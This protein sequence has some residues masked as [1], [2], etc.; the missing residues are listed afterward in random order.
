MR[1]ILP[2]LF[3]LTACTSSNPAANV[4]YQYYEIDETDTHYLVSVHADLPEN[5]TYGLI[6]YE[7]FDPVGNVLYESYLVPDEHLETFKSAA[8]KNLASY[9]EITG[10]SVE[11]DDGEFSVEYDN[12]LRME[13]R[14]GKVEM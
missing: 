7:A 3:L 1:K 2:L 14:L 6:T 9:F 12:P 8:P 10:V 11:T 5:A 4:V 13:I